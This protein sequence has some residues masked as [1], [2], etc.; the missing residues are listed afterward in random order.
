VKDDLP[1]ESAHL[2]KKREGLFSRVPTT[3]ET[4]QHALN[5]SA[6]VSA[7]WAIARTEMAGITQPL[8][9]ASFRPSDLMNLPGRPRASPDAQISAVSGHEKQKMCLR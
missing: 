4:G 9:P 8:Q 2:K 5:N 6:V 3:P 1:F 7:G